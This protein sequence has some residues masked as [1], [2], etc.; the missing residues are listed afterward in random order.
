MFVKIYGI[1]L[2]IFPSHKGKMRVS[3]TA[4]EVN[5]LS[6]TNTTAFGEMHHL[7]SLG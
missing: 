5:Y 7:I 2:N 1:K 4:I 6:G 3:K